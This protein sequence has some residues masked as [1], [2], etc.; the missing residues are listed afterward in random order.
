MALIWDGDVAFRLIACQSRLPAPSSQRG[1]GIL[2]S[3]RLRLARPFVARRDKRLCDPIGIGRPHR[4]RCFAIHDIPAE[5]MGLV[6]LELVAK[7]VAG[8]SV[9]PKKWAGNS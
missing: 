3:M 6:A 2:L 9:P 8:A 7:P 1:A 4:P 5:K